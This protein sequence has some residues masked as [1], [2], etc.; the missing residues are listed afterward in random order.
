MTISESVSK[1][2]ED[3]KDA[4]I[5]SICLLANDNTFL[6]DAFSWGLRKHFDQVI[7]AQNGEEAVELVKIYPQSYFCAIILDI[8]MPVMDGMEACIKIN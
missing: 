8:D 7:T 5:R 1:K 2:T 6:L 4:N 3:E